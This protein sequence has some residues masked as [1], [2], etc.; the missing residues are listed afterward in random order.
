MEELEQAQATESIEST[1]AAEQPKPDEIIQRLEAAEKALKQKDV[2]YGFYKRA[3]E[4][5][6]QNIDQLMPYLNLDALSEDKEGADPLGD[7][8]GI[9]S[10][11]APVKKETKVIGVPSNGGAPPEKSREALLREASEKARR[12]GRVEDRVA[13]STLKLKLFGGNK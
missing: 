3:N 12:T 5:G 4:A 7:V 8:I 6:I 1:E 9:L 11:I 10:G 2:E 13:F